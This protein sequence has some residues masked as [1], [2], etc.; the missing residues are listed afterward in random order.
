[1]SAATRAQVLDSIRRAL[2]RRDTVPLPE[3]RPAQ[4]EASSASLAERFAREAE[5]VGA[6]VAVAAGPAAARAQVRRWLE[7]HQAHDVVCAPTPLVKRLELASSA[8]TIKVMDPAMSTR[9]RR[10]RLLAAEVGISDADY[11]LADTGT[12]VVRATPEQ[13]RLVSLAPPVHIALLSA[14]S[15]LPNLAACFSALN[16]REETRRSSLLTFITG[17]SRTADIEQTLTVGVHGPGAL[18]IL[19]LE[20]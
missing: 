16:P 2:T 20:Q 18:Y 11:G 8:G 7:A 17:P 4:R 19:L 1:M 10:E 14:R 9:E 3:A 15:I 5:K 6:S 13:G 12:L